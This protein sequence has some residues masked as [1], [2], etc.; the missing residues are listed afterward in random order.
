MY[1]NLLENLKEWKDKKGRMPLVLK[2]ARQV[3]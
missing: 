1:R 3:G 2:G